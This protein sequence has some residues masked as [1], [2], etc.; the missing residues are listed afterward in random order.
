MGVV[1]AQS[2]IDSLS[3]NVKRSIRHKVEKGEWSG[4]APLGYLNSID[5]LT[6]G[7]SIILDNERAYLIKKIFEEYATNVY[8]LAELGASFP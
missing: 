4:Q 8:S 2:Y 1:M 3:D 7:K 6:G 5:T